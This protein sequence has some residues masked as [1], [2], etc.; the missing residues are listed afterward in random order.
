MGTRV[1][2]GGDLADQTGQI[3]LV[4]GRLQGKGF[5]LALIDLPGLAGNDAVGA[6]LQLAQQ[7]EHILGLEKLVLLG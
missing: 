4:D 7:F 5:V 1:L 6:A 3:S 2:E